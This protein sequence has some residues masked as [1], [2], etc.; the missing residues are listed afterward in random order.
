VPKPCAD[1]RQSLTSLQLVLSLEHVAGIIIFCHNLHSAVFTQFFVYLVA[2]FHVHLSIYCSISRQFLIL[3][4]TQTSVAILQRFLACY[5][6]GILIFLIFYFLSALSA[7]KICLPMSVC[8]ELLM[9]GHS[10]RM[11]LSCSWLH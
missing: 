3:C 2:Q 9:C 11:N 8:C 10:Y 7:C 6:P 4:V 5:C 1:D